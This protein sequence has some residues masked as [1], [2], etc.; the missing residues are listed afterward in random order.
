VLV[1]GASGFV[2]ARLVE[3][4]ALESNATP[5]VLVRSIGRA[6]P[7]SRLPIEIAV[8]DLRDS[9][10]VEAAVRGCTVVI[11]CARGTHG[12]LAERRDVDVEGAR[13]I[14]EASVHAGVNRVVH[15]S[16]IA[17][18]RVPE[19]G[20][21][22]EGLPYGDDRDPYA[23][24]KREA[25]RLALRYARHLPV[26]VVQPTVVYGPGAGIH[27]RDVIE[28]LS[29]TRIPLINAGRGVCNALYV[30]DLVTALL[31]AATKERA[32]GERFLISGAEHP[33]WGQF[34]DAFERMLG[35]RRTVELTEREALKHW[36]RSSRRE[37]LLPRALQAVR[38]D[39]ALRTDLL[40]TKEG[41]LV[42]RVAERVLPAAYFAPERWVDRDGEPTRAE[43][44]LAAFKPQVVHT[45]ASTAHVRID[46]AREL[47]GYEPAFDFDRGMSLTE[48]WARWEGLI[49]QNDQ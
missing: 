6:A 3:R 2:G 28:E 21:V 27:G 16:T 18:Y 25:E 29:T 39:S 14:L 33:T 42:R 26:V 12:T 47:L 23:E 15:T 43:L 20:F 41:V 45:L 35:V 9:R 10:A 31:L 30:D 11:H 34:Y 13:N 19:S 7:L 44:P 22:D 1:T 32:L 36:K 37:W 48:A 40:A 4:L 24:A 8:G 17:V 5:R 38:S 49:P 46:K